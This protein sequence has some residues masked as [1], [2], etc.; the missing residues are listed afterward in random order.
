MFCFPVSA[1]TV[2]FTMARFS[3]KAKSRF[4]SNLEKY[5]RS[6]FG[7]ENA[8]ESMLAQPGLKVAEREILGG[9][10]DG[11]N[12]GDSIGQALNRSRV[13]LTSVEVEIVTASE[14]GGLLEKGLAHLADYFRRVHQTRIKILRGLAYP[15]VLAHIAIPLAV[16]AIT[17]ISSVLQEGGVNWDMA[18]NAGSW[19]A[20]GYI[21]AIALGIFLVW[22]FRAAKTS[23]PIDSFL[24]RL[25]LIGRARKSLALSRFCEVFHIHMLSG[26][27][28]SETLEGAGR[29]AQSGAIT[30]AALKGTEI[31]KE[32]R[33]LS[34]A[35]F[36]FAEAYPNDFARGIAAAEQSGELDREIDQWARF[37]NEDAGEAM[38]RLAEWTP[39]V[40]Y[41]A[42]VIFV[43]GLV[44]R[45]AMA[46]R[47]VINGLLDMDI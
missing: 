1:D 13:K 29:A 9:I 30:K 4:Y 44:I 33:P 10:V 31:V 25:P 36:G 21:A 34:D 20:R 17:M 40:F 19:V 27:R 24:N 2:V 38:D 8:C 18:I 39:K 12:A 32:G 28:M 43:A 11:I 5:A 14:K 7:I 46:Y 41:F 22:V 37:Y 47:D 26:L 23:A 6:G 35:I 3:A 42:V 16:V 15:F 45:I